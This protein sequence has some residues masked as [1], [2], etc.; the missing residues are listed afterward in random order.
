MFTSCSGQLVVASLLNRNIKSCLLLRD[1]Q[2]AEFL[3]GKQD[4]NTLKVGARFYMLVV[5]F[6]FFSFSA[7]IP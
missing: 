5:S 4:E 1:P 7:F 6:I 3:F 2:K